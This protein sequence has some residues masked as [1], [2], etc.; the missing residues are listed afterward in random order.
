MIEINKKNV[1]PNKELFLI[2]PTSGSSGSSK[3]VKLSFKNIIFN[4]N[5]IIKYTKL[6]SKD[7]SVTILPFYYSYG[8]S[9]INSHFFSGGKILV[10]NRNFFD[11]TFW[12]NLEKFKVTNLSLVPFQYEILKKLD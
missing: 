6:R 10:T 8:I 3:F 4:S 5:A 2:L 1:F 9:V 11:P 12:Q 7:M